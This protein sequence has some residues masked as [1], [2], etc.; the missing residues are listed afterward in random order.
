MPSLKGTLTDKQFI[1][2]DTQRINVGAVIDL[3]FTDRLFRRHII[4]RADHQV[5]AERARAGNRQPRQPEIGQ[6]GRR[7]LVQHDVRRLDVTVEH[8]A[9]VRVIERF[10]YRR[11]DGEDVIDWQFAI[12][13]EVLERATLD[14]FHDDVRF[15]VL[16]GKIENRHDVR[17]FQ[18][19]DDLGFALE[20]GDEIGIL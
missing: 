11:Q 18:R 8:A 6:V 5:L 2:D 10:A 12:V 7:L 14:Q 9:S 4:G 3:A 16:L 15:A 20:A 1:Q 19:S 17:M 13:Q